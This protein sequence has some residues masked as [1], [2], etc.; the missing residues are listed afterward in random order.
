MNII[1][2]TGVPAL[3]LDSGEELI[4]E[5]GQGLCFGN[6]MEKSLINPIQCL[7]F[8]IQICIEPTDPH[9]KLVIQASEDLFAPMEI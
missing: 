4:L 9:R 3:A 8:R 2:L 1:T 6:T 7:K 5:F